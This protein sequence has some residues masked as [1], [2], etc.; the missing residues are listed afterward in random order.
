MLSFG[1]TVTAPVARFGPC[2]WVL[3]KTE[4][5]EHLQVGQISKKTS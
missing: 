5:Q 2:H 1:M 4:V 3:C